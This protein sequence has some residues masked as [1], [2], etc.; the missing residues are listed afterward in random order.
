MEKAKVVMIVSNA[1]VPH[2]RDDYSGI[3]A[4]FVTSP[5]ETEQ[6]IIEAT[7][8]ADFVLTMMKPLPRKVIEGMSRCRMIYNLGTG[9]EAIDLE[10]ATEQGICVSFPGGYCSLEVAE[11]AMGLI[12]DC[13]RKICRLDR[14][15]RVG[16]WDSYE[17]KEIRTE[18]M[19]PMFQLK[20]QTVG[21][22]GFGRIARNIVPMAK[23]FGMKVLANDPYIPSELFKELGVEEATIDHIIENSDFI[24]IHALF[25]EESMHMFGM[26]QFK[27]MKKTAYLINC[28]RGNFIDEEALYRAVKEGEIAGAGLD[29]LQKEEV[30]PDNPLLELESIT[31]TPH[32]AY[33]SMESRAKYARRPFEDVS[34][35]MKGVW[36]K[37]LVN[38]EVRENYVA[39][40]GGMRDK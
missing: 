3:G 23:G 19:P 29:V 16:K 26:E 32:A 15:V 35:V 33:Y 10:A 7:K 28:A 12:L 11:H 39:K 37:C 4:D 30:R 40:W 38:T 27:K 2:D 31:I 9:Y 21:L 25:T 6:E 17:K 1:L 34:L 22:I 24:S 5:C 18:I 14:A 20:G 36:P 8:D 13:A